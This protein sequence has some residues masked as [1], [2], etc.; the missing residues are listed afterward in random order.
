MMAANALIPA[1]INY[2]LI[3]I[4]FLYGIVWCFTLADYLPFSSLSFLLGLVTLPFTFGK[5]SKKISY[6][7]GIC[8]LCLLFY[9]G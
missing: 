7:Y 2:K 4:L 1:R 8:Q 6:R 5:Q 3:L 9:V